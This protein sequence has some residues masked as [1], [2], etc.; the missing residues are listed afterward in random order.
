MHRDVVALSSWMLAQEQAAQLELD[1]RRRRRRRAK[2]RQRSHADGGGGGFSGDS[3]EEEQ[4][5]VIEAEAAEEEMEALTEPTYHLLRVVVIMVVVILVGAVY[6]DWL[7]SAY[8]V[9][10]PAPTFVTWS[11]YEK[12]KSRPT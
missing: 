1:R 11:R 5:P 7:R 10:V 9:E 8:V 12:T 2:A 4:E 3:E 6:L